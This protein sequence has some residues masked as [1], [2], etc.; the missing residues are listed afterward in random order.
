MV[1]AMIRDLDQAVRRQ[2]ATIIEENESVLAVDNGIDNALMDVA[3][4][5]SSLQCLCTS[6]P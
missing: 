5:M 4:E 1:L 2:Y 6:T 3:G